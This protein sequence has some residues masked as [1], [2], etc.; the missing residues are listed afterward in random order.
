MIWEIPEE[1]VYWWGRHNNTVSPTQNITLRAVQQ[2]ILA[3]RGW[4]HSGSAIKLFSLCGV[5]ILLQVSGVLCMDIYFG[6]DR[7]RELDSNRTNRKRHLSCS[8]GPLSLNVVPW[9]CADFLKYYTFCSHALC[10]PCLEHQHVRG[11]NGWLRCLCSA[12]VRSSSRES[13]LPN[14]ADHIKSHDGC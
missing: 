9:L 3:H 6:L 7:Q 1:L 8:C 4:R 12:P 13:G 11:S 5:I 14:W 2:S 10:T